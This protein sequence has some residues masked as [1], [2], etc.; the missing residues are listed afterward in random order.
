MV[1]KSEAADPV[2]SEPKDKVVR[3]LKFEVIFAGW[4]KTDLLPFWEQLW[5]GQDDLRRAANKAIGAL[6][7][8]KMGTIPWPL[9]EDGTTKV[10]LQT[11]CYQSLSG[12]WQPYGEPF[13]VPTTEQPLSSQA[14]LSLASLMFT[15]LQTDWVAIQ[16]GEKSLPTWRS[17]PLGFSGASLKVDTEAG[18]LNF[19]VWSGRGTTR[20]TV[21]PRKI[22]RSQWHALRHALKYGDGKLTWHKPAGRKGRWMLSLS[23]TQ[24]VASREVHQDVVCAVRLGM[25]KTAT[26]AFAS[27]GKVMSWHDEVD[28]PDSTWRQLRRIE[29]ERKGRLNWNKRSAG[30]REGRGRARKLRVLGDISDRQRRITETA[31]R[32]VSAAVV[33][34]AVRRGAGTIAIPNLKTWSVANELERTHDLP[35]GDRTAHRQWYFRWHQGEL[36][37]QIQQVAEKHGMKIIEINVAGCST[38]C[39]GCGATAPEARENGRWHCPACN[40]RT[41]IERNTAMVLVKRAC[42]VQTTPP[43]PQGSNS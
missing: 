25:N 37:A 24:P 4:R 22:D 20:L 28:V 17:I 18:T 6:F 13:Y 15:R 29:S 43:E 38:E 31:I 2:V 42:A 3:T 16:R 23:L 7:Q 9:K 40:L 12:K 26:L 33:A 39:G 41:T 35:E 27:S 30:Q 10:P 1:K 32:Q 11:L 34:S 14:I 8:V 19:P 5:K 21:R 36:R